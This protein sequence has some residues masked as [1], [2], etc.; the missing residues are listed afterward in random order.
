V[1]EF[2]IGMG[3]AFYKRQ[4]K[5]ADGGPEKTIFSLRVFPIGGFCD[6]G[7]DEANEEPSH[8]RNKTVWQRIFVL[9]SGSA[10]NFVLGFIFFLALY[11]SV[12]GHVVPV[13]HSTDEH[14]PYSSQIETGDR[15]HSINGRRIY[16]INDFNLFLDRDRD[17]PYTFVMERDGER[18][19]VEGVTRLLDDGKRF[20]FVVYGWEELT[21][22]RSVR[23]A[24]T[25]TVSFV[26]LVWIS[27][28]DIFSGSAGADDI[29][30]IVGMGDIVEQIVSDEN[31]KTSD[32]VR[33]LMHMSGLIAVNLAVINLLP[34]PALDGGRIIFL[35]ISALLLKLRGKPLNAKVEA[36][37][38]SITMMLLFALMIFIFY[39]DIMRILTRIFGW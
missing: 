22:A 28:G 1:R 23:Q 12:P 34:I 21:F 36:Y 10:M 27:F 20:G 30:G 13:I 4:G 16:D 14:F 33:F 24:A 7:E 39:N 25:S 35:F 2:A 8:F 3:P 9:I 31:N 38:H 37:I 15:F 17:K 32:I 29:M 19:T 18:F 11:L 26:R 6:M 5:A